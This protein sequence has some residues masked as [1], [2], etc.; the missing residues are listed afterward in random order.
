MQSM[1]ATTALRTL[2]KI[3]GQTSSE[4][5]YSVRISERDSLVTPQTTLSMSL[6]AFLL[7]SRKSGEDLRIDKEL[8]AIL[9]THVLY[10]L[11]VG[12]AR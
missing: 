10:P 7:G 1:R 2:G 12:S 5:C 6:S 3:R 8:D 9:K 4:Q 11:E